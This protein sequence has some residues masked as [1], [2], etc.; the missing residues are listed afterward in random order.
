MAMPLFNMGNVYYRR[1]ENRK[2]INC[3]RRAIKLE[4]TFADAYYNLGLAYENVQERG[5]ARAAFYQALKLNPNDK[6]FKERYDLNA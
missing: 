5:R 1:G 3:Y 2:A 4:P 6:R